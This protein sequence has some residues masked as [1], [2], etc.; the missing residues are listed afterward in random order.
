MVD[1]KWTYCWQNLMEEWFRLSV[2]KE[3]KRVRVF[4]F[5]GGL[6]PSS[7]AWLSWRQKLTNHRWA[8]WYTRLVEGARLRVRRNW[9]FWVR[10]EFHISHDASLWTILSTV[11]YHVIFAFQN[12]R[13]RGNT[14]AVWRIPKSEPPLPLLYQFKLCFWTQNSQ[15]AVLK[16]GVRVCTC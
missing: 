9:H 2:S 5:A 8:E 3:A 7:L 14:V 15:S 10:G 4:S 1:V 12:G 16:I 13:D 6:E 11:M